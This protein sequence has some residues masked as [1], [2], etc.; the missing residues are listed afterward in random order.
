MG[1]IVDELWEDEVTTPLEY[2]L[3]RMFY[4]YLDGLGKDNVMTD[5]GIEQYL[6]TSL[7]YNVSTESYGSSDMDID[8]IGWKNSY[9]KEEIDYLENGLDSFKLNEENT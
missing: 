7:D 4:G 1:N 5:S 8:G 9:S 2:E 3:R 6:H